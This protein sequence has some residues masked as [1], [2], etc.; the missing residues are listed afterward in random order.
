MRGRGSR[1]GVDAGFEC[2]R[3]AA[4]KVPSEY[5]LHISFLRR[6]G[7]ETLVNSCET[8]VWKRYFRLFTSFFESLYL[9][10]RAY[11]L[12]AFLTAAMHVSATAAFIEAAEADGGTGS[13]YIATLVRATVRNSCQASISIDANLASIT[14]FVFMI[15]AADAQDRLHACCCCAASPFVGP[16]ASLALFAARYAQRWDS[17][18]HHTYEASW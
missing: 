3:H 12:L 13:S 1:C 14:G 10:A 15:R 2:A 6:F 9:G 7:Y 11:L 16:A 18:F 8:L 4:S 5:M 17:D